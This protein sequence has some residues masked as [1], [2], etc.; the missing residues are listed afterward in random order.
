MCA[1]YGYTIVLSRNP[2][3]IHAAL[4]SWVDECRESDLR[5]IDC[6]IR[7]HVLKLSIK[8]KSFWP[9]Y[10]LHGHLDHIET[11]CYTLDVWFQALSAQVQPPY[12]VTLRL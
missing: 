3:I 7:L 6:F 11:V 10:M 2:A 12:G 5:Y 4:I 8:R 9:K 1:D